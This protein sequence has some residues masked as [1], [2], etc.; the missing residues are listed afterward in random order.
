MKKLKKEEK[1]EEKVEVKE[2]VKVEASGAAIKDERLK[3]LYALKETLEVNG[4]KR[5]SDLDNL[6]AQEL[7]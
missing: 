4:I 3:F 7:K 6:I 2:E 1:V 5:I